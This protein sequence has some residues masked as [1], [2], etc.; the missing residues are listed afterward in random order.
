MRLF[1]LA[2]GADP[3][4]DSLPASAEDGVGTTEVELGGP[5]SW[6]SSA[7]TAGSG[8][9]LSARF[10]L[11]RP[12]TLLPGVR[13]GVPPRMMDDVNESAGE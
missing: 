11:V 8:S 2:G 4:S 9:A 6:S 12:R 7:G 13:P 5:R 10:P 1:F 3:A